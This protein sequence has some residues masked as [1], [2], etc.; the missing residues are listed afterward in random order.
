MHGRVQFHHYLHRLI[1]PETY[2]K[3]HPHFYPIRNGKRY[4]PADNNT[5]GWQPCFS[6][7]GLAAEAIKTQPFPYLGLSGIQVACAIGLAYTV[8]TLVGRARAHGAAT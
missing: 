6:A 3:T 5:H 4:F 1:P 7:E 2:A 8:A